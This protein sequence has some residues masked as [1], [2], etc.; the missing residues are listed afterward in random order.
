MTTGFEV[1]VDKSDASDPSVGVVLHGASILEN[2]DGTLA[3]GC[4]MSPEQTRN[5]IVALEA[6]LT[7][8]GV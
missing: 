4:S 5:L 3:P 7:E 8:I 6:T 2:E 1:F